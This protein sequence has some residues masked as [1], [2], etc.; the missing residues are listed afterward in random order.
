MFGFVSDVNVDGAS[1]AAAG[2]DVGMDVVE[3]LGADG[4]WVFP[5]MKAS[6]S[7]TNVSAECGA[8]QGGADPAG[9]TGVPL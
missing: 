2:E 6:M 3:E 9:A 8:A 5:E 7:A 1:A 4:P